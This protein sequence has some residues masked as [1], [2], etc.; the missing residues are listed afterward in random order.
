M[1]LL[2]CRIYLQYDWSSASVQAFTQHSCTIPLLNLS[3]GSN[4]NAFR[5]GK[6]GYSYCSSGIS[7][8][9]S[10]CSIRSFATDGKKTTK[11]TINGDKKLKM[12]LPDFL[13]GELYFPWHTIDNISLRWPP[14]NFPPIWLKSLSEKVTDAR[15]LWNTD[16]MITH[17]EIQWTPLIWKV[18][19]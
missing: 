16:K 4:M 15:F 11:T 18:Y 5:F 14:Q 8:P 10:Y 19:K 9:Y 7:S 12:H 2:T 1:L 3:F 17:I 6:N 13:C